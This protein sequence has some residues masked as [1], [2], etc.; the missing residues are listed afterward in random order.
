MKSKPVLSV[1]IFRNDVPFHA[2][3]DDDFEAMKARFIAV[4]DTLNG[5]ACEGSGQLLSR[6]AAT[7]T[8]RSGQSPFACARRLVAYRG[9]TAD[10]LKDRQNLQ[11]WHGVVSSDKAGARGRRLA[12]SP[13]AE[14]ERPRGWHSR[15][16]AKG[17]AIMTSGDRYRETLAA[18]RPI[19]VKRWAQRNR[20][21]C[22]SG[23]IVAKE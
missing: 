10:L 12:P 18:Q 5:P 8:A 21:G 15:I 22:R 14:R 13:V 4:G 16:G 7:K 17:W 6:D 19:Y 1:P 9:R 23:F 11:I 2:M 3:S 20:E